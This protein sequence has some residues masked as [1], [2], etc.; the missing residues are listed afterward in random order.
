MVGKLDW[1]LVNGMLWVV[2]G[3]WELVSGFIW[4]VLVVSLGED[5]V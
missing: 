1:R 5:F 2:F 3:G 4:R